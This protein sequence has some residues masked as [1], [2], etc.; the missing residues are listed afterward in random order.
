[1]LGLKGVRD[2][3]RKTFRSQASVLSGAIALVLLSASCSLGTLAKIE[4]SSDPIDGTTLIESIVTVLTNE[5]LIE[6]FPSE[7]SN[8][9]REKNRFFQ[10]R[11]DINVYVIFPKNVSSSTEIMFSVAGT[12]FSVE[13]VSLYRSIVT[14]L[15]ERLG[16]KKVAPD[17]KTSRGQDL[18]KDAA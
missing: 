6:V 9:D 7:A 15:R 8:A 11:S 2:G 1:M 16:A 17:A 3:K 12:Q 14:Q 18:F 4:I 5:N 13:T 10:L